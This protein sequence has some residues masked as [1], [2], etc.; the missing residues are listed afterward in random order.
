MNDDRD[1]YAELR[2]I[3]EALDVIAGILAFGIV[4]LVGFGGLFFSKPT[5]WEAGAVWFGAFI[6]AAYVGN[7]IRKA[8]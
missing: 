8:R 7:G 2:K 5:G 1:S 6:V 3:R 4:Y